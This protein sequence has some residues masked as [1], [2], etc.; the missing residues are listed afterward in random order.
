M[1]TSSR[2]ALE[3]GAIIAGKYKV[4]RVLAKGGMGVVVEAENIALGQRVAVK[5]L[6]PEMEARPDVIERFLRE[7]RAAARLRSDH[8]VRVFDIGTDESGLPF[9][10]ME[11]LGG[12]DLQ[13]EI[14]ARGALPVPEAVGYIIEA[15]DAIV[16]AHAA[17]IIHR[18]L[19]PANI[20]LSGKPGGPRRVRVLD[21]G[22]SKIANEDALNP[23]LTST[24]SMLGSPAYMSPEQVRST[25]S[26]DART[27]VWALGLILYEMLSGAMGFEGASLGDIFAKIRE[28]DLPQLRSRRPE[29]SEGLAAVVHECLVR[30]REKRL[31]D[32][33]T[34]RS[35]L[36]PFATRESQRAL[37][38]ASQ[39]STRTLVAEPRVA[40]APGSERELVEHA[41]TLAVDSIASSVARPR[42]PPTSPRPWILAGLVLLVAGVVGGGLFVRATRGSEVALTHTE[43]SAIAVGVQTPAVHDEPS[44]TSTVPSPSTAPSAEVAAPPGA[45][46]SSKARTVT[47]L[48]PTAA[49]SSVRAPTAT[50]SAPA[51]TKKKDDLGL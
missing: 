8:V 17:G 27:D 47:R 9:M 32:A 13:T 37:V 3:P 26:V 1:Q 11:L 22:I 40:S 6:L 10:V 35:R 12:V 38:A 46:P 2:T 44:H 49:A 42:P 4:H 15:L 36:L 25:K 45:V 20:F 5:F 48:L 24:Q 43:P 30:D 29:V 34:L 19:K 50:A 14:K 16:E 41:S 7:A 51:P 21:F 28:E 39:P 18:D 31:P 23:S 33:A